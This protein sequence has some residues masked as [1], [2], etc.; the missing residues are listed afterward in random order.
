[1]ALQ[2]HQFLV[3]AYLIRVDRN[4]LNNPAVIDD[5]V[6]DQFLHLV[7]ETLPVSSYDLRRSLSDEI[8]VSLHLIELADQ[9]VSEEFSFPDPGLAEILRRLVDYCPQS[10]PELNGIHGFLFHS[11]DIRIF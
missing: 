4:F 7:V 2:P 11:Q 9:V 5:G 10:V 3:Y 6:S 1:M 8:H